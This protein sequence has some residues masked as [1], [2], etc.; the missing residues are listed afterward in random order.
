[1]ASVAE[2]LVLGLFAG[3]PGDGFFLRDLGFEGSKPGAFV[4]AV[5]KR[6]RFG[7][8]AG[9]PPIDARLGRLHDGKFLKDNWLTHEPCCK[10]KA[11]PA[12]LKWEGEATEKRD[13]LTLKFG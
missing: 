8:A 10:D 13:H 7:T 12:Q 9:A 5:A 3:A 2:G 4:G 11:G 1:V 6:L